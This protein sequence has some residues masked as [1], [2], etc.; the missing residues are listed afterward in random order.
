M[1][2]VNLTVV[3]SGL[4]RLDRLAARIRAGTAPEV[5]VDRVTKPRAAS[6][7][8]M[9]RRLIPPACISRAAAMIS[10]SLSCATSA[11]PSAA[12]AQPKGASPPV[13]SPR[14]IFSRIPSRVLSA[15]RLRS[16]SA[17]PASTVSMKRPALL[18]V[19]TEVPPRSRR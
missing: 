13:N 4:D 10:C 8:P 18:D 1:K 2:R 12:S 9:A 3:R 5:D 7:R 11:T 14:S 17:A 16:I 19:S 15:S 6:S